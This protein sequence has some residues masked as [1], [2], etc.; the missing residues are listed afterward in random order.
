L[1]YVPELRKIQELKGKSIICSLVNT[2]ECPCMFGSRWEYLKENFTQ[3]MRE[4]QEIDLQL[5]RE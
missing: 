4:V 1:P 3:I 5:V 2:I